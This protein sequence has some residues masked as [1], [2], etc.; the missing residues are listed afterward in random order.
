[1]ITR[2][3]CLS[4][5]AGVPLLRAL[6]ATSPE[7]P[8]MRFRIRTI[9]AGLPLAEPIDY[10]AVDD[11]IDFL[12]RAKRRFQDQG[13]EV[14]TMR[15]ASQPLSDYLPNWKSARGRA[16]LARLDQT[17]TEHRI[18]VSLGPVIT[19]DQHDSD[20]GPWAAEL[21]NATT[22]TSCSVCVASPARGIHAQATRSAAEAVKAISEATPGGRGNFRFAATAFVPPHTPFFPAAYHEGPPAFAIGLESPRLLED[23]FR[24]S[25]PNA[26]ISALVE[27]LNAEFRPLEELAESLAAAERWAYRGI[28][29]S[30]APGPDASIGAAIE[31]L[32]GRPFGDPATLAACAAI[33]D[34][35]AALAVRTC[36]YSGLMLPPMEDAV[37][38]RRAGEERYGVGDLLLYSSVC[39][40]GLDLIPLPGSTTVDELAALIGDVAALANKY[41][42][43][44]SARLLPVPGKA[45]GDIVDTSDDPYLTDCIVFPLS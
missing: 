22:Q 42:K 1:M 35:L 15:L 5:L 7:P 25:S 8:D 11:A 37:L 24:N 33:T 10:R 12:R 38:A 3:N 27:R 14:Q 9:T 21:F 16:A 30:P 20:F 26:A 40:T 39:G 17:A 28:D 2:R 18:V 36:G 4:L 23:V 31:S 45:A 32:S 29:C 41:Q 6:A 19:A 13:Y 34:A 43:P 44:L